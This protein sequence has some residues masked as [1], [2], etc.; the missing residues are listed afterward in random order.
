MTKPFVNRDEADTL[1]GEMQAGGHKVGVRFARNEKPTG[2]TFFKN[3]D[4]GGPDIRRILLDES[5]TGCWV[6]CQF[7]LDSELEALLREVNI[8]RRLVL[9]LNCENG[10][11]VYDLL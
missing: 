7:L 5:V 11:V 2:S 10:V 3:L 6:G 4:E 1:M 9:Y 8:Q